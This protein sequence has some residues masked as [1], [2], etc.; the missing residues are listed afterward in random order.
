MLNIRHNIAASK[1][2]SRFLM[3]ALLIVGGISGAMANGAEIKLG[4]SCVTAECHGDLSK[5]EFLHGPVNLM[6]CEPCHIPVKNQHE[7]KPIAQGRDLCATCHTIDKPMSVVHKPFE[8]DCSVCHQP[9]GGDNR[10]FVKGG[11]G[12]GMCNSCHDSVTKGMTHQHGPVAVG[13]CLVCHTPHQ[14]ENKGLLVDSR[15]EL[16][17]GCHIDVEQSMKTAIA[18]HQPVGEDCAG[19]HDPHGGTAQF[20]L[21][22]EGSELCLQCHGDFIQQTKTA[23]YPHAPMTEG[24]GCRNCHAP[25]ASN[26]TG[27]L[28]TDTSD[29][30][31]SCHNQIIPR[32][33]GD[34]DNVAEQI[35]EAQFL[36]GP[37]RDK[38]CAACHQAH[39]SDHASIL[40]KEFPRDFYASY[41]EGAYDL[42]FECHDRT[43]ALAEMS[44]VT[45]FRN[46]NR[47]LHFVHVNREK[48]RTCRACH[49]EHASNQPNHVRS[50]V[51]FGRWMMKVDFKKTDTGGT[52]ETGCHVPY[53][54]DRVSAV[55][56]LKENP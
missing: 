33:E 40:K 29:L 52:C 28:S 36:H 45:G 54:Y 48:G 4:A 13:E 9:H 26:K 34:I 41:K 18:V 21:P 3:I 30:C 15:R 1:L 56:N 53:S 42:C 37:V 23:A 43:I 50:E 14:S 11:E 20:F 49:A 44:E 27:L 2:P 12:A 8:S 55:S 39:G 16:C 38:N 10:H 5:A 24:K 46:G 7:F 17:L 31:L 25:H 32:E 35:T 19:C 47:N 6:Q 22:A 51:P